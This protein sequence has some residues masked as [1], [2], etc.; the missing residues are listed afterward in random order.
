MGNLKGNPLSTST[1]VGRRGSR[2]AALLLGVAMLPLTAGV[3]AADAPATYYLDVYSCFVDDGYGLPIDPNAIP[4]GSEIVVWEGWL[5]TKRGQLQGF[6][7]N[8][9][10]IL[11]INGNPV[12]VTPYLSEL[13]Y[14][15]GLFWGKFFSVSAGTLG[16]GESMTTHYDHE[17]KAASY[18]GVFHYA[19]GSLYDGGVDCTITAAS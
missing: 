9:T 17:L 6:L 11:S 2:L 10:W 5:A 8:V 16:A 19:R 7:N 13:I 1:R 4:A 14:Y 3:V 12:D 15:P 18:D